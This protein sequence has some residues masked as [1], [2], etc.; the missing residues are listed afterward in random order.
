VINK[1]VYRNGKVYYWEPPVVNALHGGSWDWPETESFGGKKIYTVF[2]H[3]DWWPSAN[4]EVGFEIL[5]GFAYVR[6]L[7]E[8]LNLEQADRYCNLL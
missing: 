1:G 6:S 5:G 4:Q 7:G 3:I 2:N 8:T